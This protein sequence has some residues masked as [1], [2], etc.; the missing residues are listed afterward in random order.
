M[1]K[2]RTSAE[3]TWGEQDSW[4]RPSNARAG[5]T[6][7]I[8]GHAVALARTAMSPRIRPMVGQHQA[9]EPTETGGYGRYSRTP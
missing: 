8:R 6:A 3:R 2:P 4:A 5:A 1:H 9:K 7:A